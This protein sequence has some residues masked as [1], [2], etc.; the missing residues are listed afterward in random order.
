MK[1]K[2]FQ[3]IIDVWYIVTRDNYLEKIKQT[4]L[5]ILNLNQLHPDLR[6]VLIFV[7]WLKFLRHILSLSRLFQVTIPTVWN[8]SGSWLGTS[9]LLVTFL[10]SLLKQHPPRFKPLSNT[11]LFQELLLGHHFD[12]CC[13]RSDS[14]V[15]PVL[16]FLG[17]V[18]VAARIGQNFLAYDGRRA[19]FSVDGIVRCIRCG[20]PVSR[21]WVPPCNWRGSR[22]GAQ[23]ISRVSAITCCL[24]PIIQSNN[25]RKEHP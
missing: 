19:A 11:A 3:Q 24:C 17:L 8:N 22:G 9:Q 10:T 21:P 4:G 25:V 15:N 18:R 1:N 23:G 2:E 5:L 12:W 16:K 13:I 20:L 7:S 6:Q 14:N